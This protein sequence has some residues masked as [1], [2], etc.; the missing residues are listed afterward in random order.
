MPDKIM[1]AH[2]NRGFTLIELLVTISI[3]AILSAI[4]IVT[5]SGVQ[6]SARD[7]KRKQDLNALKTSL[8]VYKQQTGH[9][10]CTSTWLH[11]KGDGS[12]WI[13]DNASVAS[14]CGVGGANVT[15]DAR[16]INP[17]PQDPSRNHEDPWQSGGYG[18]ISNSY[19]TCLPGSY[20]LLVSALENLSDKDT[21]SVSTTNGTATKNPCNNYTPFSINDGFVANTYVIA[22]P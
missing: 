9:Y 3:I 6:V 20:Y 4:G 17:I 12:A 15:F 8:E 10:P 1:P 13:I 21:L 11:S 18:Y 14:G 7:S 2:K 16:Y 22:N 5:F 19:L